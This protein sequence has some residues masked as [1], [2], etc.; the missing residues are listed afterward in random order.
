MVYFQFYCYEGRLDRP[1][2]FIYQLGYLL[3]LV[4]VWHLEMYPKNYSDFIN[5]I[6]ISS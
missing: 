3:I 5:Y 6:Q 4:K 1:G 2:I